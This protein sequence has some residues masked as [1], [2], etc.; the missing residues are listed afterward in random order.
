MEINELLKIFEKFNQ[1]FYWYT[2]GTLF[3]LIF[4]FVLLRKRQPRNIVAY[5][6]KSGQVMVARSAIAELVQ[7]SCKQIPEISKP[8]VKI[9]VK[10]KK[11]HFQVHVK[12]LDGGKLRAV[13]EMLQNHLRDALTND[14]G[15][16]K[17]GRIDIIATG[18]KSKQI[19]SKVVA[20]P[21]EIA[22]TQPDEIVEETEVEEKP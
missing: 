12:L 4:I 22:E 20:E 7:T 2:L 11:K 18:F 10:G 21:E 6:T 8:T 15:I 5:T 9:K 14:L 1:P 16:E 17:L 13:E 3:V 19:D